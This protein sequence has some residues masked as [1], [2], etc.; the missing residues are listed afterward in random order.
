MASLITRPTPF[1]RPCAEYSRGMSFR[2]TQFPLHI[3]PDV[4][5][6][7]LPARRNFVQEALPIF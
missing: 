4:P 2:L 1:W 5:D 6:L 7:T 3:T